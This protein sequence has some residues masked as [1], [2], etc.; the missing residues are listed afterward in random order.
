MSSFPADGRVI[1][2]KARQAGLTEAFIYTGPSMAPTFRPGCLLYV[3]P[4]ARDLAPGDVV[5]FASPSGSYVV[6]R[7]VAASDAGLITRGDNNRLTDPLPVAHGQVVGR[8]ELAEYGGRL[9]PVPGGPAALRRA[10]AGWEARR[11]IGWL[12]RIFGFPYRALRRSGL[13]RRVLGPYLLP[14]LEIV[15]L[16]TP[17]GPVVKA[18]HRGRVV[19]RFWPASGRS[20]CQK[21]YDLV[22]P[23]PDGT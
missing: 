15:R 6:H 7:V 18:L 21:P 22:I 19:A 9:T 5:V 8:V 3:R 13:A 16:E 12:R 11:A 2:P 14:R 10:R 4:A 17:A 23:R 20:E 1:P